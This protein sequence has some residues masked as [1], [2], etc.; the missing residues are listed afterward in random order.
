MGQLKK[1]KKEN[2][3]EVLV[4]K[5]LIKEIPDVIQENLNSFKPKSFDLKHVIKKSHSDTRNLVTSGAYVPIPYILMMLPIFTGG[6]ITDSRTTSSRI[7]NI[8]GNKS[9]TMSVEGESLSS[10]LCFYVF[11]F[12]L[13]MAIFH[14]TTLLHVDNNY[15][16]EFLGWKNTALNISKLETIL[17]KLYSVEYGGTYGGL[18]R[19]VNNKKE[20]RY[21]IF[22]GNLV[23]GYYLG[24]NGFIINLSDSTLNLFSLDKVWH[25]I[26]LKNYSKIPTG[27]CKSLFMYIGGKARGSKTIG[28]PINE[29]FER[30]SLSNITTNRQKVKIIK[31]SLDILKSLKIIHD[32]NI[33]GHYIE[34]K[35]INITLF[36]K[37]EKNKSFFNLDHLEE[38]KSF[39]SIDCHKNHNLE[40]SDFSEIK[41]VHSK[42]LRIFNFKDF[43]ETQENEKQILI[44][45]K[46]NYGFLKNVY[47][48]NIKVQSKIKKN[49]GHKKIKKWLDGN[50][51]IDNQNLSHQIVFEKA[52]GKKR[53]ISN[54]ET[55]RENGGNIYEN[56]LNEA[57]SF[58][59]EQKENFNKQE[60]LVSDFLIRQTE[61]TS[62]LAEDIKTKLNIANVESS[63]KSGVYNLL[64]NYIDNV[65]IGL[66]HDLKENKI[67]HQ[68]YKDGTLK[69]KTINENNFN[70]INLS[71]NLRTLLNDS[72]I[73][74]EEFLKKSLE[75]GVISDYDYKNKIESNKIYYQSENVDNKELIEGHKIFWWQ[76]K[77]DK[78]ENRTHKYTNYD[79]E[80]YNSHI[81]KYRING[82]EHH[83]ATLSH[84]IDEESVANKKEKEIMDN[85]IAK[86][87]GNVFK[88]TEE[89]IILYEKIPVYSL[90]GHEVF[91]N[92]TKNF[93]YYVANNNLNIE[94]S[95][96]NGNVNIF[97][98]ESTN[99]C[100][101]VISKINDNLKSDV[102]YKKEYRNI[103]E[104]AKNRTIE[105]EDDYLS[106][107][108]FTLKESKDIQKLEKIKEQHIL[109]ID[110]EHKAYNP[111]LLVKEDKIDIN[112]LLDID[113][114]F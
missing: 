44:N 104:N 86:Y 26:N 68:F 83:K 1:I 76:T 17:E 52:C 74:K 29:L 39:S 32:Y 15:I 77:L 30:L 31:D 61:S 36:R 38:Y 82:L 20:E 58:L 50:F 93:N 84:F 45:N 90:N 110:R 18:F 42:I 89:N 48:D 46:E 88:V 79:N 25:G 43:L 98:K 70:K 112:E 12:L 23:T 34:Q 11:S 71:K 8:T 14:K 2:R 73:E 96:H 81:E 51:S 92:S 97:L 66:V 99:E 47:D 5:Q 3:T 69:I 49:E 27:H 85:F 10:D 24:K 57:K 107:P 7:L 105:I 55:L 64:L 41:D 28:I 94:S 72:K 60:K 114:I 75:K 21:N 56:I 35:I 103:Y 100:L 22:S 9:G 102:N 59:N 13:Q 95:V 101:K 6:K 78:N 62:A 106:L 33:H 16:F 109:Q 80:N 91:L 53:L 108:L 65:S 19:N 40:K 113:N 63:V 54:I 4:P 67:P 37:K 87:I 111:I